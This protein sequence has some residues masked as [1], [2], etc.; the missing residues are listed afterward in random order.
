VELG[1]VYTYALLG[2]E[3]FGKQRRELEAA[4]VKDV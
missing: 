3:G 4:G 2:R 1:K